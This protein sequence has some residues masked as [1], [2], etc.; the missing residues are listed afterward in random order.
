MGSSEKVTFIYTNSLDSTADLLISRV[1]SDKIFRFNLDL[2]RDY[3]LLISDGGFRIESPAGR[4][5]ET[6]N[7]AKF[8]W[9]KP[10]RTRDMFPDR[11]VA[12]DQAYME[13]E[14]WYAMREVVNLIRAQG[15]LVLTEPFGD[16][17][18][19]K[20]IQARIAHRYFRT[21]AYKF[22]CGAA[23][24]LAP[25]RRAVVKSLSARRIKEGAVLYTTAVPEADLDPSTPWMIQD[26]VEAEKDVTVAF[27]RDE[28]FAFDLPRGPFRDRTVDWREVSLEAVAR[29]WPIHALPPEVRRSVF[30]LME[31][32]GL[33]YARLDLLY[34]EGAYYFLE[35]N[36][37]G[38][39]GWLDADGT[40]GLLDKIVR[41]VSPDTP[42][43]PLP[44]RRVTRIP[45]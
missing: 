17:P 8:Y 19:G 7:V 41:E 18:A 37:N 24:A 43:H 16:V 11:P 34:Q 40:H 12:R 45:P 20:M 33:H 22:V 31:D 13:E 14:L 1:G 29:E 21:P 30:S 15:K 10:M 9:R 32:L 23:H 27:V 38:E 5:A 42:A 25:G 26:L 36:S 39:W 28:A 6:A 35:A 3:K 44:P 2:W 4:V